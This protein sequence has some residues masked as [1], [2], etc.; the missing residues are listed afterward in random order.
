MKAVLL[1]LLSCL[2]CS[3]FADDFA[4]GVV[5]SEPPNNCFPSACAS[6]SGD[7]FLSFQNFEEVNNFG[8]SYAIFFW[9][10]SDDITTA[11]GLLP[12]FTSGPPL[13]PL[14]VAFTSGYFTFTF[15]GDN[16]FTHSS[17]TEYGS[18]WIPYAV[19]YS[20]D[21]ATGTFFDAWAGENNIQAPTEMARIGKVQT[22]MGFTGK[23]ILGGYL[24]G[25]D[26]YSYFKGHIDEFA[27][28]NDA[29][30]TADFTAMHSFGVGSFNPDSIDLWFTF[31]SDQKTFEWP[32]DLSS[33]ANEGQVT[34][35]N[36]MSGSGPCFSCPSSRSA[37]GYLYS[38]P[39]TEDINQ[40]ITAET[41]PTASLV[42]RDVSIS[43]WSLILSGDLDN[44]E[45]R[46]GL[47][48]LGAIDSSAAASSIH[49]YAYYA[50]NAMVHKLNLNAN[51]EPTCATTA[52]CAT[53][54]PDN[55]M[56]WNHWTV[57]L[58]VSLTGNYGR[59]FRNG[60]LLNSKTLSLSGSGVTKLI[61]GSYV[62]SNA[63]YL[64][65][66]IDDFV[67]FNGVLSAS[68]I[69][70]LMST[71]IYAFGL[72]KV[73]IGADFN[74][75][76]DGTNGTNLIPTVPLTDPENHFVIPVGL[77]GTG[78]NYNLVQYGRCQGA[79]GGVY[80]KQSQ[81]ENLIKSSCAGECASGSGCGHGVA[82]K[83]NV[84]Q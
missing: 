47:F 63:Y 24:N 79:A 75:A 25:K 44:G 29:F 30:T 6:F 66:G 33:L 54:S 14:L 21:N 62:G 8:N 37:T 45:S 84:D 48:S 36:A 15:G 74:V 34:V 16:T 18:N 67:V 41:F 38:F 23:A 5:V 26:K 40:H 4:D 64:N 80:I 42:G 57:Q 61:L 28:F 55:E 11:G 46:F 12:V 69:Q 58:S 31:A 81:G 1:V 9:A 10:K 35:E 70:I 53:S 73:L 76:R 17:A 60:L 71:S 13:A 19:S 39:T 2:L 32:S 51:T 68:E 49:F 56:R 65:G 59:I 52:I 22:T 72:S 20:S 77:I 3:A 27:I 7:S 43:F 83:C 50:N 78:T 82:G